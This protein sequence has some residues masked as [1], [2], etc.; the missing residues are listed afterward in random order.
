MGE[1]CACVSFKAAEIL[2]RLATKQIVQ[3]NKIENG[4]PVYT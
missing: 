2:A 4:L 1:H 3:S